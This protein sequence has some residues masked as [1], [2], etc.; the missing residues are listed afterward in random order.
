MAQSEGRRVISRVVRAVGIGLLGTVALLAASRA[1]AQTPYHDPAGRFSLTVPRG[2]RIA[3][4]DNQALVI[5][6]RD[7]S[8][9]ITFAEGGDPAALIQTFLDQVQGQWDG[10]Q[11]IKRGA[12]TGQRGSF[13]LSSGTNPN[14]VPSFFR[15]AT[16]QLNDGV[17][18]MMATVPQARFGQ[19]KTALESLENSVTSAG[20]ATAQ[21]GQKAAASTPDPR[22]AALEQAYRSGVLTEE[23]YEAKKGALIQAARPAQPSTKPPSKEAGR[24]GAEYHRVRWVRVMDNEGWG[25]PEEILR[26]LIPSHW[27]TEGGVRWVLDL[28]CPKNIIQ[29]QFRAVAPDGVTGIEFLPGY[30]WASS[31]DPMMQ[32]IIQQQAQNGMGCNPGPVVGAVDFLRGMVVPQVRPGA[33]VLSAELLP[34]ATQGLQRSFTAINQQSAAAGLQA[35]HTGEV[36]RVRIAYNL[37]QREVEEWISASVVAN[38]SAIMNTAAALQGNTS[39]TS[40]SYQMT[41]QDIYV[42][43]AARGQLESKGALFALMYGSIQFNPRYVAAVTQ[44]FLNIAKINAQAVADRQRI[45]REA[46]AHIEQ[47]RRDVEAY[48][49]QVYERINDQFGQMIRGVDRYVDPRSSERVELSAGYQNAWSN[50][51]GEYILSETTNFDPRVVLQEDWTPMKKESER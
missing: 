29:L 37:G 48:S 38:I 50:G 36:G 20:L 2:W 42:A 14:G 49:N 31:D 10:L 6:A 17:L 34:T 51:K 11:E 47:S 9:T 23:E 4:S 25:Q 44:F 35:M 18:V 30:T 27:K 19:L 45:W 13:V 21:P 1:Y 5:A 33:N 3:N 32:Q 15:I 41:G 12:T 8:A 40:R 24:P 22:L 28:G 43:R 46:Q 7:A 26:M 39:A 16:A